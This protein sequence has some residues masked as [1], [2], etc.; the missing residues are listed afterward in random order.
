MMFRGAEAAR[1]I[2]NLDDRGAY[3][4]LKTAPNLRHGWAL[5]ISGVEALRQG[6]RLFLSGELGVWRSYELGTLKPVP[7]RETLERQSGMYAVTKKIT[8]RQATAMVMDFAERIGGCLKRILWPIAPGNPIASRPAEK[9]NAKARDGEM[10]L[11][12]HEACNL[13]V[14]GRAKS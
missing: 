5:L 2:A 6:A 14:A 13:L 4:P 7:L 8:D 10:P 3:R 1:D 9:R 11:L 12:C